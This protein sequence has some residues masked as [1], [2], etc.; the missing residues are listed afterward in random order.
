MNLALTI[1]QVAT[2]LFLIVVGFIIRKLG[3]LN[4]ERNKGLSDLLLYV[5]LPFSIITSF[6]FP[7]SRAL[8]TNGI[9]VLLISIAIHLFAIPFSKLLYSKYAPATNRVLRATTVFS[10]CG[11]MGFPILE[12][13]Y[14][15]QGVF[16]GSFYVLTF[17]IL[18]WTV[19]VG[20]FTGKQNTTTWRQVL[21]PA[22][23]AVIIGFVLFIFSIN[24]PEPIFNT[25]AMVGSMTTPISMLVIGS[26]LFEIKLSEVFSGF[27]I[28]YVTIMRLIILPLFAVACLLL[29]GVKGITLGVPVLA[30]AMPAAALVVVFAE[31]HGADAILASRAVFLSTI[32]SIITIPGMI[33]LVQF[34]N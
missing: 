16:Y 2:L 28:F 29:L 9:I 33:A 31:K 26:L 15:T 32:L 4:H 5:T 12:A 34:L 10:N 6:N 3:I 27:S 11:F 22:V 18:I 13:V 24:L 7:F 19:G 20:I 17:Q 14:G 8:L 21:N 30:T 25:L 1:N 23:I